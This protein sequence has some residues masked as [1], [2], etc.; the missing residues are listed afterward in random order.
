MNTNYLLINACSEIMVE[1]PIVGNETVEMVTIKSYF[2]EI[3]EEC[4]YEKR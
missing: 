3:I 2:L 1:S 4:R